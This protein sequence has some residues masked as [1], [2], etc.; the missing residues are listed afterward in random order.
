MITHH[1]LVPRRRSRRAA[2][3]V[4][5]LPDS[6]LRVRSLGQ[7]RLVPFAAPDYLAQ[8]G[9]P[10]VCADLIDHECIIFA[11]GDDRF[12]DEWEFVSGEVHEKVHVRG[13]FLTEDGR[14]M[15]L[16]SKKSAL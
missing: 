14:A 3:R 1:A 11:Y 15:A 9:N 6:D 7:Y 16:S 5:A 10:K 2:I 13:R 12:L 4:G 8:H